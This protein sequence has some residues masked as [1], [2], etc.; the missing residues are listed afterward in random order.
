MA[1]LTKVDSAVAGLP[2]SAESKKK[3]TTKKG[4]NPDVMNI[5]DLGMLPIF[6]YK[7]PLGSRDSI[8]YVSLLQP[9]RRKRD[10]APN[11]HRNTEAQLVRRSSFFVC[12]KVDS[13][14]MYG[15]PAWC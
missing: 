11:S 12:T 5:K 1:T 6:H 13:Y 3:E 8:A 15:W 2:P 4:A 10:R 9:C 7:S 14:T